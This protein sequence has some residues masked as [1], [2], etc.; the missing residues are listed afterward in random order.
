MLNNQ[1]FFRE[2][3]SL[4]IDLDDVAEFDADLAQEIRGNTRRYV[5]LMQ[6]AIEELI[7]NY[8]ER[9][10]IPKDA[11]DIYIKHRYRTKFC[12][13]ILSQKFSPSF[14]FFANNHI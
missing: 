11:L 14:Q 1:I 7:P 5:L 8:K 13:S 4:S 9:E 6:E 10:A 3:E 12:N 2:Q